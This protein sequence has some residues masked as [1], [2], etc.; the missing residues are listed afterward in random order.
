[1]R[2][3][4]TMYETGNKK[5]LEDLVR[6]W[7][8]IKNLPDEDLKSFFVIGGYHGEPFRGKGTTDPKYWGG[9]CNH[10]NVLFPTWHRAYVLR[11]E[12]ALQSIVPDVMMPYWDE[13][14]EE[15]LKHGLPWVLTNETFVLDGETIENPLLSYTF[16]VKVNDAVQG[17]ENDYTKPKG[18]RTV[19]YPLS[20]IVGTE[21]A[22]K[23]TETHN[24]KYQD[25]SENTALLDENIVAWLKGP[26]PTDPLPQT[27][28]GILYE[29][30][31]CLHAPNYT[32]FSN[33]TSA[34]EWN[35]NNP[36]SRVV[37][38]E[39]PHN[40]VHLAVGG[41]DSQ[42]V[43]TEPPQNP[44][45][46]F[47]AGIITGSNGDMGENDTAALDP[48][49]FFHHCNVD[50]VFWLWQK[51]NGHI[52]TLEIM[53]EYAGTNSSDNPVQ[54]PAAG[55]KDN[56]PLNLDTPLKPFLK[57]EKDPNSWYA[58]MDCINIEK[59]LGYTYSDGSLQEPPKPEL[60][61]SGFSKKKLS[62]KGLNRSLFKGS[63]VVRAYAS[64][65]DKNNK[66]TYHYLGH[67]SFLSRWNV[68]LC[69][70]CQTHLD[71]PAHFDLGS[72][73]EDVIDDAE[74][75]FVI[76]SRQPD[77]PKRLLPTYEI[78]N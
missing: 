8:G 21:E 39:A 32:V 41:F 23:I 4:Q 60:I 57:D 7:M 38:L 73:P 26:E 35:K 20:G 62:L 49:F 34:A 10:G 5:P 53:P 72:I 16:P 59:Q 68:T 51:Q 30:E 31:R 74:F 3:L 25:K 58:S 55:Q 67:Q 1:M 47:E 14:S 36:G 44:S 45:G 18:Y 2:Q 65:K 78:I 75:H 22:R 17:D 43:P 54:G 13:T 76:Y 33:T 70:N 40:D 69:A 37:P 63:F 11:I 27:K 50:R 19:R 48:I 56:E 12:Q 46:P 61:A 42:E 29:Y 77:L 66:T 64:V 24:R 71:V 6:A 28:D 9:Y 15:T 52:D